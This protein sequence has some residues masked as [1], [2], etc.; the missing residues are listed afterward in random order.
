MPHVKYM[1]YN[2]LAK[3]FIWWRVQD[4]RY[5]ILSAVNEIKGKEDNLY[6]LIEG[7]QFIENSTCAM[8]RLL[9]RAMYAY[10]WVI[11]ESC[12]TT[13]YRYI[14]EQECQMSLKDIVPTKFKFI[15]T[16]YLFQT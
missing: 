9:V 11:K 14:E 6:E 15:W 13:F 5:Q 8:R 12:S 2:D 16:R 10:L 4:P 7:M 1:P 3:L